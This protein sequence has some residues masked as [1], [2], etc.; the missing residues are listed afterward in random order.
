MKK[1]SILIEYEINNLKEFEDAFYN[2]D[3]LNIN[4]EFVKGILQVDDTTEADFSP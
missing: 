1:W 4:R 2:D 3:E